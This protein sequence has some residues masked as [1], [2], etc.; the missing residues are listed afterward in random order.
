MKVAIVGSRKLFPSL[1]I[2]DKFVPYN[3][4]QIVSGGAKGVDA[5]ARIYAKANNL[6]MK[7]FLPEFRK[8]GR[9]ATIVRNKEIVNYADL[10]LIFWD[11][12]SNGS[13][14]VK[15]YCDKVSKHYILIRLEAI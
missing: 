11:G 5:S 1:E 3:V 12:A 14:M 15:E 10:V 4:S 6:P 8:Y 13:N 2:I 7:E 9:R